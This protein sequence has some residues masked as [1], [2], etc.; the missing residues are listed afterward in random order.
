MNEGIGYVGPSG[1]AST[2]SRD[3]IAISL[4]PMSYAAAGKRTS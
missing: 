2:T 3:H 1:K 4:E